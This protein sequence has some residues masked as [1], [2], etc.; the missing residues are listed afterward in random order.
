MTMSPETWQKVKD[1]F[2]DGSALDQAD[3][4]NFA[5]EACGD[6]REAFVE[7]KLLLDSLEDAAEFIEKPA[8][9]DPGS[10][11]GK[12]VGRYLIVEEIGRGGMGIVFRAEREGGEFEQHVAV[13]VLKRG[14]DTEEIVRRFYRERQ[15]LA[16]LN[17][18][19][20]ARLLDGGTT[21]DGL[22]YFVMEYIDGLPLVKY[23]EVNNCSL[24][25]KIRLFQEICSAVS[26]AH[27]HLIVHRDLKPDNILV[28]D[29]G[30][31]KL[32]DFGL[33]RIV[34]AAAPDDQT[35]TAFRAFTPGYASP[36]QLLGGEVTTVSDIYS[37]GIVLYELLTNERPFYF[38]GKSLDEIIK[39]ITELEAPLPSAV[40]NDPGSGKDLKLRIKDPKLRGDLDNIILTALRKE[41]ERRY[42]SVEAFANDIERHLTGFPV[43]ARPSTY[44][45]RASK[46]IRRNKVS[47][48]AASVIF[49]S[50]IGA[51]TV[52]IWQA[53][54]TQ[55]E[56]EKVEGVNAFL[57][58]TLK[59][60]NPLFGHLRK[61]GHETTV[62]EVLDEAARRLDNGEFDASPELKA[63]LEKTVGATYS[64]QAK[65]QQA[66]KH[67]EQ[68][69]ILLRQ[70]Y[71]ENDPVMIAGSLTWAGLLFEKGEFD[72]A[73]KTYRQYLP[74][75][76]NE[77]GKGNVT[78]D[79][80]ANAYNNFAY[81]RRTQGA[82]MEAESLFR[83][84][85][86]LTP[87][88]SDE[89]R[90]GLAT[91]RSTL[92]STIA[93]QG[94]FD[95][96][97]QSA[98]EA[99]EEYRKRGEVDSP[100]YGFSLTVLGGFLAEKGEFGEADADLQEA[101]IIFRHLNSPNSLWLGD[102]LRNQAISLYGEGKLTESIAKG[103]ETLKIYETSFGKNYDNY[104]TALIFK[105]LSLAKT[106]NIEAG[107]KLLREAVE[108]R[109]A[110]LPKDHYWVALAIS[111]LGE[112]LT[113]EKKYSE[114]EPML[115]E[116][117]ASLKASQGN[118][119]PRTELAVERLMA[120][121]RAEHKQDD[122]ARL[123]ASSF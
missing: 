112:C 82:S 76:K 67:M 90:I 41:P 63:E 88:L 122:A 116:A 72:E 32:L 25:E 95:E 79:I 96:A 51:L 31:P 69:V 109:K 18:P 123:Q 1:I 115:V 55:K 54:Q 91:T 35:Q 13:K 97:L 26:Y 43:S 60:S 37:L 59:Y 73:E 24:E 16:S 65:Y 33:A 113:M 118:T 44:K 110:T 40:A 56:K 111:A 87:Q 102:N 117:A 9:S 103:D 15:I 52:G 105:G 53:R 28:T 10:Y 50:V 8:I 84:T 30:E 92:A 45:Y 104:P 71:A 7:V 5:R 29:D 108:I 106:G 34:D 93:D 12:T 119:N 77:Y 99:V 94:R 20:I 61:D 14:L 75:L 22:P 42:Q 3:R 39:I 86:E 48:F 85:L 36:E 2:R 100:N 4:E 114:A 68:Y 121:Y 17:H 70:L 98:R 49:L 47:V 101:E 83:E 81:L 6:D 89:S 74:L 21:E 38:K 80:L 27:K 23:C 58:Q 11:I 57:E 120:L 64:G 46:F 66:R 78:P 19:N 62:N 107:E